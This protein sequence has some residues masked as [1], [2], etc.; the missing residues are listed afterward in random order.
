[1]GDEKTLIKITCLGRNKCPDEKSPLESF[2]CDITKD[3]D[4]SK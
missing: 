1:M 2:I 4:W 3:N